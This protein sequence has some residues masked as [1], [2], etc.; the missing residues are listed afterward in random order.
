MNN[1]NL[2]IGAGVLVVGYLL[3]TKSKNKKIIDA[4][5]ETMVKKPTD[6]KDVP[7]EFIVLG[8][9]DSIDKGQSKKYSNKETAFMLQYFPNS[10][11]TSLGF[12][13]F[14]TKEQFIEAY[15]KMTNK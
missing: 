11:P 12:P 3:Y 2:L 7:K 14:V 10:D 1:R 15:D 4:P 9:N 5:E 8:G 6:I 13:N